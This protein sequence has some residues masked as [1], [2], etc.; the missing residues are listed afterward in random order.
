[1]FNKYR[2]EAR[3]IIE[4]MTFKEKIGQLNQITITPYTSDMEKLYELIRNG[5]VGS[6]I[7]ASSATAGNDP[8]GHVNMEL[9]N[10]LQKIAV[11]ESE[12]GIPILFGRDVIH[13][14]NTVY[15]I[16]LA[17]ASA[18]KRLTRATSS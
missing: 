4:K 12:S 18:F 3:K 10:G 11:E 6:I 1:M 8:Q 17:M 2:I 14:H 5:G 9:Y 16:P 15:P 13:G 7:L